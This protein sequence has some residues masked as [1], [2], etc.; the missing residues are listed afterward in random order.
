LQPITRAVE[1]ARQPWPA[2]GV[3]L[4]RDGLVTRETLETVVAEQNDR[5]GRRISSRRLGQALVDR[6]LVTREQV[7]RLVAEQHELPFVELSESE[8]PLHLSTQLPEEIA[9]RCAAVPIG[10]LPDGSLIIAVADPTEIAAMDD[11]R[12]ALGVRVRFAVADP[13]AVAGAI[14]FAYSQAPSLQPVHEESDEDERAVD[15][16]VSA[17]APAEEPLAAMPRERSRPVF[18]SLLVG[19]GLITEDDLE[20]ALAQQR[21]SQTKRLGEILVARGVLTEPQVARVLAEQHELLYIDL[22]EVEV[23]PVAAAL[24]PIELARQ[25]AALPVS[26]LPDG[27]VLVAVADPTSVLSSD[28]IT[29]VIGGAVQF[30]VAAAEEVRAAIDALGPETESAAS[31]GRIA[32]AIELDGDGGA[33]APDVVYPTSSSAPASEESAGTVSVPELLD[34]IVRDALARGASGVHVIPRP[35][36]FEVRARIDKTDRELTTI[37][38][39]EERARILTELTRWASLDGGVMLVEADRADGRPVAMR[40]IAMPTTFGERF[41]LRPLADASSGDSTVDV[42]GANDAVAAIDGAIERPS[43]M[44]VICGPGRSGRTS[45]LYAV[46]R[47]LHA[48]G[49][50]VRTVEEAVDALIDGIEQTEVHPRA[51]LTIASTLHSLL[52]SDPDVIAVDEVTD[53]ETARLAARGAGSGSMVLSIIE[54]PTAAAGVARL[55]ALGL[56]PERLSDALNV[57]LAQ[58]LLRRICIDCREPYFATHEELAALGR[59]PDETGRRLLGRGRGCDSCGGTGYR[60]HVAVFEALPLHDSVRVLIRTRAPAELIERAGAEAGMRTLRDSAVQLCLEGV[61]TPAELQH[62]FL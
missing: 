24:L 26:Y 52:R 43:G 50:A 7:A 28:E 4:L 45:T 41:A 23:D 13:E 31:P 59:S 54:A 22:S 48:R 12:R 17:E 35:S 46:L 39:S 3:L 29:L 42:I 44:L 37:T 10:T 32:P 33:A 11:V 55:L 30:G 14:D 1:A 6:G 27:S 2:L 51:G 61:T 57:V 60:G 62:A 21:L 38:D 8:L 18:G 49:R 58:R 16:G 9:R 25:H 56:E 40:V 19:N 47:E 36:G 34:E 53:P 20:A 5:A 15:A